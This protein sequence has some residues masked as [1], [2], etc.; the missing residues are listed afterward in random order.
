MT[1]LNHFKLI[2]ETPFAHSR[3]ITSSARG[4][5]VIKKGNIK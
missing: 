1:R 3:V 2:T 4:I 5:F